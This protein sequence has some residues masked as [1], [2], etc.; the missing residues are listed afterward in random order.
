MK[1][2]LKRNTDPFH[3]EISN[4]EGH[5]TETDGSVDIGGQNLGMRPM[6]L[7]LA[8]LASC[9]SIDVV[10]ILR[11]QRQKVEDIRVDVSG[12]RIKDSIPAVFTDIHLHFVLTGVLKPE[13]VEFAIDR[14]VTTYC[15][16]SKMIDKVVNITTSYEIIPT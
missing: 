12:E 9:S 7:F 15:S 16:V 13:K 5:M 3:F 6:E 1:I 2:Q 14:S 10:Y 4:A 8:S 11:K